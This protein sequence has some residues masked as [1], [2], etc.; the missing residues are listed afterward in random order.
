MRNI[1][2]LL[3]VVGLVTSVSI[4][5]CNDTPEKTETAQNNN[6][7][8]TKFKDSTTTEY[9]KDMADYKKQVTDTITSYDKS[10][11][12]FKVRI[13]NDKYQVKAEYN[14]KI[15]ELEVKSTDMKKKMDDY[16]AEGKAKWE[17][18]KVQFSHSMDELG[19]SFT[20]LTKRINKLMPCS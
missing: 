18:F 12:D 9:M 20:D 4:L 11:A 7:D 8:S 1:I 19:K 17:V 13:Q 5:S 6:I 15:A 16:K 3:A 2:I 14:K 10:I